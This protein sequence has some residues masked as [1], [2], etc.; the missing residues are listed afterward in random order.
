MSASLYAIAGTVVTDALIDD[1]ARTFALSMIK[2]WQ[3]N[4]AFVLDIAETENG[5]KIVEVNG[6]TTSGFY[7]CDVGAIAE[8][9][10]NRFEDA[11]RLPIHKW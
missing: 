7:Q 4:V 10:V 2:L 1:G 6:Y 11:S 9:L 3:P 5:Y 8:A